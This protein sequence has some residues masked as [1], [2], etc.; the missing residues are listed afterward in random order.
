MA[1]THTITALATAITLSSPRSK[2]PKPLPISSFTNPPFLS[3]RN[4]SLTP[5]RVAAPPTTIETN[6]QFPEA[7]SPEIDD[8]LDDDSSSSK[9]TWRDHWYPV[10]LIEDLNPSLPT[11]FQLLGREIVLWYDNSNSQWVAFDDKCPHR[12]APLSVSASL[13][14]SFYQ[15]LFIYLLKIELFGF[16]RKEELM[17]VEICSVLIMVGL[18]MGVDLVLW[19]LKLHLKVLKHVLFDLLEHVLLGSLLWCL[20]VCSLFGLMRMVGIK[21]MPPT[22][23]CN[24]FFYSFFT[25]FNTILLVQLFKV[26]LIDLFWLLLGHLIFNI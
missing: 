12:L 10:S 25:L 8:E 15:F 13:S 14:L 1:L 4:L 5:L 24:H 17:R 22:L 19:S 18:L 9:F 3:R 2:P 11:P 23:H 20:R 7:E 21:Q 6:Q 26:N 16:C